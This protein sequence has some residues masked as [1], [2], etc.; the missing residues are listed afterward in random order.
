MRTVVKRALLS[1]VAGASCGATALGLTAAGHELRIVHGTAPVKIKSPA[2]LAVTGFAPGDSAQRVIVVR[3]QRRTALRSVRFE[4]DEKRTWI[5]GTPVGPP[6]GRTTPAGYRWERTC[7]TVKRKGRK[8][9]RRCT[10]TMRPIPSPLISN[11][12]G[13]QVRLDTCSK[14][15][16]K[17]PTAAPTYRCAGRAVTVLASRRLP[18]RVTLKRFRKVPPRGQLHVRMTVTLPAGAG[19][20]L[21]GLNVALRPTFIAGSAR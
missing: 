7:K 6:P 2:P 19:N 10:T 20:D 13:L 3:N 14:P 21:Q 16:T 8:P 9:A 15:W 17:L 18:V 4:L 12:H 11:A 5:P 1:L